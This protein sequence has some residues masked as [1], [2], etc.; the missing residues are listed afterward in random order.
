MHLADTHTWHT[1]N[2]HTNTHTHTHTHTTHTHTRHTHRYIQGIR[3]VQS[4][5]LEKYIADD[6]A[7]FL[8][9]KLMSFSR[10]AAISRGSSAAAVQ[11]RFFYI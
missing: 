11:V 5:S 8:D 9:S 3:E 4:F 10:K 2:W 6:T 7:L 1:H